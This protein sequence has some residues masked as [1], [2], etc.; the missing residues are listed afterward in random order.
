MRR[1]RHVAGQVGRNVTYQLLVGREEL[2]VLD[3][4]MVV[5][6]SGAFGT[7]FTGG[8][9]QGPQSNERRGILVWDL[10]TD[11]SGAGWPFGS[12]ALDAGNDL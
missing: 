7:K 10:S 4:G 3:V 6:V 5:V 11:V 12:A 1:G 9:V 2:D 8:D